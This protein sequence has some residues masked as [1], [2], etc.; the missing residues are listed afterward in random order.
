MKRII[1]LR[2]DGQEVTVTAYRQDDS[3]VIE[4]DGVTHKVQ[5]LAEH[6]DNEWTASAHGGQ[7][8]SPAQATPSPARSGA[9]AGVRTKPA[10]TTATSQAE[11]VGEGMAAALAPMPGVIKEV[12]VAPGD[13]VT[14]GQRVL[15]MEAMK[16][17]VYVNSPSAGTVKAVSVAVGDAV[18]G[19]NVLLTVEGG[20][21]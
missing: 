21:A 20:G 18:E 6:G 14:E 1:T 13:G 11:N 17:D 10:Q 19:G 7:S 9:G 16:M 4:R 2:V 3:I 5:V 8:A 12:L 15:V